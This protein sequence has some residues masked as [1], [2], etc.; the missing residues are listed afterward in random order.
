MKNKDGISS[1]EDH[2]AQ[3][4]LPS[5]LRS[6]SLPPL[7]DFNTPNRDSNK[8]KSILKKNLSNVTPHKQVRQEEKN[9]S[10]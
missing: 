6:K 5:I 9:K 10:Q 1:R 8:T 7:A 2:V 4:N 3:K